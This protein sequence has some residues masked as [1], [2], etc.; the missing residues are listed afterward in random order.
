[1]SEFWFKAEVQLSGV[2]IYVLDD[3][4]FEYLSEFGDIDSL[5]LDE[6]YDLFDDWV[7]EGI[8]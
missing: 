8:Y 5:S 2:D 3:D 6:L 1:M 4:L 7:A